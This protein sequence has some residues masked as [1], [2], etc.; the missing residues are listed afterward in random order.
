MLNTKPN[1]N[2]ECLPDHPFLYIPTNEARRWWVGLNLLLGVLLNNVP[3]L[4]YKFRMK[5][6]KWLIWVSLPVLNIWSE[7]VV[8]WFLVPLRKKK[9]ST[10][11]NTENHTVKRKQVSTGVG[12]ETI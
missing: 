1:P 11:S 8:I 2:P 10:Q 3:K 12:L 5:N 9:K 6:V 7:Q 4:P